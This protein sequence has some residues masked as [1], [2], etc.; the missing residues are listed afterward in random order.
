[1]QSDYP[2]ALT[3]SR[4]SRMEFLVGTGLSNGPIPGGPRVNQ[5]MGLLRLA[6]EIQEYVLSLPEIAESGLD[7][8]N[9]HL[10]IRIR[11]WGVSHTHVAI[12]EIA[13]EFDRI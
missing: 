1:M 6:P 13:S 11:T 4:V 7:R 12:R 9:D 10:R 5:I 2:A 8:H 3:S